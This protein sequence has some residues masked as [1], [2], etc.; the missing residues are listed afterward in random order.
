M[1][2]TVVAV[3]ADAGPRVSPPDVNVAVPGAPETDPTLSPPVP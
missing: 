1:R 3:T 2:L